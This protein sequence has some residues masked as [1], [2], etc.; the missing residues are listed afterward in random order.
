MRISRVKEENHPFIIQV[1]QSFLPGALSYLHLPRL[2]D[3]GLPVNDSP[4]TPS[5]ARRERIKVQRLAVRGAFHRA[6]H[7]TEFL[8]RPGGA[9]RAHVLEEGWDVPGGR[10]ACS[11]RESCEVSLGAAAQM[12]GVFFFFFF[13]A[14]QPPPLL[15]SERKRKNE[16]ASLTLHQTLPLSR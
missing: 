8:P 16:R 1:L 13:F 9:V 15:V 12:L 11:R 7:A 10:H 5:P 4:L 14:L 2:G 3:V 6:E